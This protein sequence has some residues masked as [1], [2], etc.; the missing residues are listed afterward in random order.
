MQTCP[1]II[2]LDCERGTITA[3]ERIEAEVRFIAAIERS[4]GD[5]E[6]VVA[7]YRAWAAAADTQANELDV[8]TAALAHC[9]CSAYESAVAQALDGVHGIEEPTFT[10]GLH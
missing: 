9:W 6:H 2:K 3:T 7:A 8:E 1:Y 4:L 10:I 5:A